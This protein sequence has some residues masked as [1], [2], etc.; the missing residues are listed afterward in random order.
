MA[1]I[2]QLDSH[3]NW[4]VVLHLWERIANWIYYRTS[5]SELQQQYKSMLI[6]LWNEKDWLQ[7]QYPSKKQ[8]IERAINVAKYMSIVGDLANTVKHRNL[9][10][11]RRS[12]AVQTDYFGKIAVSGGAK[13]HMYYVNTGNGKHEEIMTMLRGGMGEFSALRFQLISDLI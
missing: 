10:K 3:A 12:S 2:N 8:Q 4:S 6:Y 11:R 13:R 5:E 7:Q 1:L 9:N